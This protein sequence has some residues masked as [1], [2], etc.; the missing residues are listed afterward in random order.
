MKIELG[1]KVKDKISGFVGI[2]NHVVDY[3]HQGTMVGVHSTSLDKDGKLIDPEMFDETQ[4]E[5]LDKNLPFE[6]PECEKAL[7]KNGEKVKCSFTGFE[8]V[9][10]G[11]AVYINGCARVFVMPKHNPNA[12]TKQEAKFFPE[13]QLESVEPAKKEVQKTTRGG[14]AE[15]NSFMC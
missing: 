10:A 14:P 5:V 9:V 12:N 6:I 2:V 3:A 15:A 8:G 11:R 13:G 4:L 1:W 7:F